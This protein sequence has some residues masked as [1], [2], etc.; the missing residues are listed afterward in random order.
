VDRKVHDKFLEHLLRE[1]R[2]WK[3]EHPLAEDSY[4]MGPLNN[5]PTAVKTEEHLADAVK[6]GAKVLLGGKREGGRPTNLYFPATVVDGVTREMLLN[7]DE[8]FGPVAP[9]ITF[10]TDE[11]A[12]AIANESGYGLQMSVFTS[13]IKRTFFYADRLR[14][15]N[16]VVNDST[17]YWEAHEPFGGGGGTKSGYGRLGGR[18]TLED[19][20]SFKTVAIDIE[21]TL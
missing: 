17:D 13:S 10:D 5:E 1:A 12:V 11:E 14:T 20:T 16:L 19:V 9:V 6:K 4:C 18:Y 2:G 3:I 15:G 8:T 21:K 7:T